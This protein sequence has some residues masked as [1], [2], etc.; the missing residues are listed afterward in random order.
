MKYI[1]L[2][3]TQQLRHY[4]KCYFL[5]ESDLHTEFEDKVFPGG[6]MEIIFNL[7]DAVWQSAPDRKFQTTPQVE[8]WGQLTKPL[9]VRT[10]GR[11]VMLGVRFY[12]HTASLILKEDAHAFNNQIS[13]LEDILGNS[14]KHLHGTLREA[15]G[16][17]QRIL[18]L[19]HFLVAQLEKNKA[20]QHKTN[21]LLNRIVA[22][23]SGTNFAEPVESIAARHSITPRYLQK[24]FVKHTGVTPKLYNKINRFQ[25]SLKYLSAENSSLTSVAYDCGYFDQSH[26]I[27]EFKSFTGIT[28]SAY[29]PAASPINAALTH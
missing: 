28:P 26:F 8:L 24:I 25:L 11:N 3:P 22:E 21:L 12:A 15:S 5:F 27:R 29:S 20:V 2:L 23:L 13:N 7:G 19:E 10:K 14:I 4:V 9:R 18:L 16:V 1:E 6:Y 17:D